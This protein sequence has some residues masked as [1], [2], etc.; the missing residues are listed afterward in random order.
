MSQEK[1]MVNAAHPVAFACPTAQ[2]PRER[3]SMQGTITERGC[4]A[5]AAVSGDDL[6]PASR[7]ES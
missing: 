1:V 3:S 2:N 4:I 5:T 6:E 7:S